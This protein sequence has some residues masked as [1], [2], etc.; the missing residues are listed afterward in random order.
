MRRTTLTGSALLVALAAAV[1]AAVGPSASAARTTG[2]AQWGAITGSTN[3]FAT[4][5]QLPAVGFPAATVTTDSRADVAIPTGATNWFGEGTP[6]GAVY[7][8]SRDQ[9]YLNLRPRA[10]NASSPSTTVYTFDGPTPQGWTFVLGDVDADEVRVAATRADGTPA[11]M[12]ELGFRSAFNLCDTAPRPSGVCA[13]NARPKDVPT[14]DPATATLRGNAAAVDSDGATGW[15]EPTTSLR[16]LTF[17]FTRRGGF[18]VFQ[19]W[20]AVVRQDV[21]GTVSVSSGTCDLGAATVSLVDA[22]GTV[23]AS[24]GVGA[25]GGYAFDGVAASAR[26]RVALSGVP[27]TCVTTSAESVAV[28][29]TSGDATAD[30]AVRQAVPVPIAGQVRG[31]T[32]GPLA[33]VT[34]TRTPVG[35]GPATTA[36]TDVAGR[37]VF[38]D[39]PDDTTYTLAVTPPAGYLPTAPLTAVVPAGA[40]EPVTGEDFVLQALPAV[41]GTV[42]GPDG[43]LGG[44][45]VELTGPGGTFRAVTAADGGYVIAGA[46]AGTYSLTVPRPPAGF[47]P[48]RPLTVTVAAADVPDQDVLLVPVAPTGSVAGTVTLDGR[49]LPGSTIS[50]TPAGPSVTTD[51]EGTFGIGGLAPG[52][53]DVVAARPAGADGAATRSITITAAG[54][55]VTGQDFAFTTVPATQQPRPVD[56]PADGT[57]DETPSDGSSGSTTPTTSEVLPDTGGPSR[58]APLLG[59]VLTVGGVGVITGSRVRRRVT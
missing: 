56:G 47:E 25:G 20:F 38:E 29:L 39:N 33:G 48:P 7:G 53:Y 42:S 50:V 37:Y 4:T 10:D 24:R 8:S 6:P 59:L 51:A 22:E 30:F 26:Y 32:G 28:D 15:F 5:M 14:W 44:V 13:S 12:A 23:V 40:T 43:P 57:G 36:V 2:F 1:L 18:P 9:R 17:T 49:P 52:T 16:A 45:T 19:T 21:A 34:V 27:A 55:D 41:S 46:T 31:G 35:G 3:D 11:T 58:V 54:E